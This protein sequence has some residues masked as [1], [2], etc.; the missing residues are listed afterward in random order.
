LAGDKEILNKIRSVKNMQKIT[1]A[2][3]M[4]AASKI[5]K[6]QDQMHASRPYAER[7]RKV[8]GHL[9]AA[10]PD[11]KHPFLSE[12]KTNRVGIIIVSTDRGLCGGLNINLFKRVI[13]EMANYQKESIEID[14]VLVGAK[15]V[16]FFKRLG[17]N[18]VGTA[19][20]LGDRPHV[21]DL[22]GAI[23]IM[24]D[25]YNDEKID[26]L[27]IAHNEFVSTMSQKPNIKTLLPVSTID[28]DSE[29]LQSHW[30]YIYEP[31]A[32][33]L[34]DGVLMRYIESQVYRG[35]TENFACEMAAKMVAMKSATDNAGEII[36]K[37]QLV[38]NKARQAAITQEISEIVGGAAAV[39]G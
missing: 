10:N 34:L 18:V 4:V 31:D 11:Y 29:S 5:R 27:F 14:L 22:I 37:L 6:A 39:S 13:A 9:G 28:D 25:A 2:M 1:S 35:A 23:K 30:D 16:Q 15:A 12:R 20:H 21:N 7:I 36:D 3:E 19:T 38:Y 26:K 17:G 33:D 32:I 8:I 24:L